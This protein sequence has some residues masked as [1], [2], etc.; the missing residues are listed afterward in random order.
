MGVTHGG[1]DGGVEGGHSVPIKF[2][3]TR[4]NYA[5]V[6]PSQ[7]FAKAGVD[8]LLEKGPACDAGKLV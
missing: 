6:L 2:G 1:G 8:E 5:N 3:G 7:A 4:E